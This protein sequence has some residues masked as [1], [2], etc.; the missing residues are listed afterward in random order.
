M[1]ILCYHIKA[2]FVIERSKENMSEKRR[3]KKGRI[4]RV[5][6]SQ[7]GDGKYEYKYLDQ[8]GVR[9]S[10]YSWKLV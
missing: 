2:P 1:I 6:E 9:R 8:D 4:L 3:D 7:R 10:L 5:G